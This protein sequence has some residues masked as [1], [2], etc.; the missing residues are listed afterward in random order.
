MLNVLITKMYGFFSKTGQNDYK[1]HIE[2]CPN[3]NSQ[4]NTSRTG[5]R[6]ANLKRLKKA[7]LNM[8][9]NSPMFKIQR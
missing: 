9:E 4:E 8:E 3:K 7:T 5:M 6:G 2:K 1:K